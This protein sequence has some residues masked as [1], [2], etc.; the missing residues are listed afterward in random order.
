MLCLKL[1]AY[2]RPV[3]YTLSR[4]RTV[5]RRPVVVFV[6][7]ELPRNVHCMQDH[8]GGAGRDMRN[9]WCLDQVMLGTVRRIVGH[10]NFQPQPDWLALG[11]LLGTDTAWRCCCHHRPKHEQP[12]RLRI[13]CSARV[14]PP[15]R[16]AVTTQFAGVVA[17]GEVDVRVVVH[18]V[19]DPV[20]NQFPWPAEP[21]SWS[22]VST[23]SAVKV[24]PLR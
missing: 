24:V 18:H 20:R 3:W 23:V 15:Q 9:T 12:C 11:G 14:L 6:S 16:Y 10:T 8:P 19:R 22:K 2:V 7:A 17:R 13:R 5:T 21:K 1:A 4:S